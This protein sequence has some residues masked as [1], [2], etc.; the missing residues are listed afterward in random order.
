MVPQE[1]ALRAKIKPFLN[2]AGTDFITADVPDQEMDELK[3]VK[4][5]G[6]NRS[7]PVP[8]VKRRGS[9]LMPGGLLTILMMDG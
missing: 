2:A 5:A 8:M 9:C 6:V 3:G 4:E 7:H 1:S